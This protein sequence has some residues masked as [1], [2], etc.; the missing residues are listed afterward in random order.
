MNEKIMV[1]EDDPAMLMLMEILLRRKGF[2]VVTA[3]NAQHALAL[4]NQEKP[5]LF[6]LD[7]MMPGMTGL[8]LCRALRARP[9]T[10]QIPVLILSAR[11]DSEVVQLG[12]AVGAN[13]YMQKT[14]QPA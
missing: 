4:L 8:E 11:F 6:I 7:L 2:T 14:S 9:D 3:C 13:E 1:V 12:R 5:D 10:A